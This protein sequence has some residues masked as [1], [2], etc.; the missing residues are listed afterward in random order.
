MWLALSCRFDYVRVPRVALP[1]TDCDCGGNRGRV[2]NRGV[3]INKLLVRVQVPVRTQQYVLYSWPRMEL[4]CVVVLRCGKGPVEKLAVQGSSCLRGRYEVRCD[5][6]TVPVLNIFLAVSY[7][8][9]NFLS[10]QP[11]RVKSFSLLRIVKKEKSTFNNR[12]D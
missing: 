2:A 4:D 6:Y 12:W 7:S 5:N 1:G 11:I 9:A 10:T 8:H 3:G